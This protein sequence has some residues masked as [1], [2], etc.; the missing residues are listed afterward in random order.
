MDKKMSIFRISALAAFACA[1]LLTVADDS[2]SLDS[3]I[4]RA[5]SNDPVIRKIGADTR[6]AQGYS[7]EVKADLGPQLRLEGSAG[8][9]QRDRSIDGI[10]RGG[11]DL[12]SR[13]ISLIGE[14]LL[15]DGG[16][17]RYRWRDAAKRLE[18]KELLEKAQRE[19]T[20][21]YTVEAFLDV[22]RARKQIRYARENIGVHNKV[23]Q[24]AKDRA[25]AAGNQADVEL[26]SARYDLA[27]T[28]L[29]ERELALKQA[30]TVFRRYVGVAPPPVLTAP[31]VPTIDSVHEIRPEG[32]FHYQAALMQKEAAEYA[33]QAIEQRYKPNVL[34]RGTG[35]VGEDVL[36]IRG[37]DDEV[38]AL[39]VV[40]WDLFE[41][42]RKKG[43]VE[44]ALADIDRQAAIVD[45]TVV[46]LEQ[47]IRSRWADY[48]SITERIGILRRYEN[49]LGR[50][51]DLYEEQFELGTRPLL[52]TLD[53]RNEEIGAAIRLADEEY[54]YHLLAYRLLSFGG[55][56]IRE[57][58]G[59]SYLLPDD[60]HSED[61]PAPLSAKVVEE[62][63][64]VM[65]KATGIAEAPADEK[66]KPRFRPFGFLHK[67]GKD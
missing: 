48:T 51:A 7:R 59:E 61:K 52:S 22:V 28:L 56:L 20:A 21:F 42:G 18:A 19:I 5:L 53:I 37:E 16:F 66:S 2:M 49:E 54:D 47:D 3:A 11:G 30:E 23:K 64:P 34:F 10:A 39:V 65:E 27:L 44:Q 9:A 4:I 40:Q 17:H 8:Y 14:Q 1:P 31:S 13:Q 43:E 63:A 55:S 60:F 57:T 24:L 41:S 46:L 6:E 12:F 26:S 33:R 25:D 38:S 36:G 15:W 45:E 58:V 67:N 62:P 29:K 35:T 32:N 50:T